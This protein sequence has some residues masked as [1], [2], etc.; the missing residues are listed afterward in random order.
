MEISATTATSQTTA[1]QEAQTKLAGDLQNFLTLLTT[2]LKHQDPLEPMDSTEFTAQLA[3]F[4]AVEQA[5][6]TNAN[7]EKLITSNLSN[8]ALSAVGYLGK[9]VEVKGGSAA[10][11]DGKAEFAY[12]LPLNATAAAITIRNEAGVAVHVAPAQ[13]TAG[14]H[15]FTWDGTNQQGVTQPDGTYSITVT[16]AGENGNSI[17]V[18]TYAVG[19]VDGADSSGETVKLTINGIAYPLADVVAVRDTA[20]GS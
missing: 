5:I 14:R 6:Q 3:Q 16:A 20:Q 13:I 4:A 8:R 7:L 1:S 19:I 12:E 10:L 11:V 17:H 9:T 15:G 2:Q 18:E